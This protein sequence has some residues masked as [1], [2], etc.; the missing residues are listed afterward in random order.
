V[1]EIARLLIEKINPGIA[2]EYA[3]A[4]EGEPKDSTALVSAAKDLLGFEARYA[5]KDKIDTVIE[6]NR[7]SAEKRAS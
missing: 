2:P 3:I 6:W 4:P 1:A 7:V 5:L